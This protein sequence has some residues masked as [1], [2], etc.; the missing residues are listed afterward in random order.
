MSLPT[1]SF[2]QDRDFINVLYIFAFVLFIVG[3][4][5]LR[6]PR[7]AVRGNYIAG[8]GMAIAV[9]ATLLRPGVGDFGLIAAGVV[10]GTAIGIPSAIP[11]AIKP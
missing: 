3:L 2:L 1:A 9:V 11:R 4:R 7:T 8:V 5:M 10:I 6:G